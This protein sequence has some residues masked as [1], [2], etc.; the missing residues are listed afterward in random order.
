MHVPGFFPALP[1][2]P[3]GPCLSLTVL[4]QPFYCFERIPISQSEP[5][6][7]PV[8]SCIGILS[9]AQGIPVRKSSAPSTLDRCMR[10]NY[11]GCGSLNIAS[12][13]RTPACSSARLDH[14]EDPALR[15][16]SGGG[17]GK[18]VHMCR[19]RKM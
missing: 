12:P 16:G 19:R 2:R 10:E 6:T 18:T 4:P 8:H 14:L 13:Y 1:P 15:S 9:I 3:P 17:G 7:G 5:S 11:F